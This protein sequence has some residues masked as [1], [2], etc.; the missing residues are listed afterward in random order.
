VGRSPAFLFFLRIAFVMRL[1]EK[2]FTLLEPSVVDAGFALVAVLLSGEQKYRALE[3]LIER[4]NG[5]AVTLDD[6]EIVS[7]Q[8]SA[9]LEV[10]DYI[11]GRYRLE[12]SSPGINRPLVRPADF[13]RFIGE[14]V[15]VTMNIHFD[16]RKRFSGILSAADE[17]EFSLQLSDTNAIVKLPYAQVFSARLDPSEESLRMALREGKKQMKQEKIQKKKTK[18]KS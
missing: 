10:E 2:I 17:D 8:L 3:I 7:K 11:Q 13:Q 12:V 15:K 18:K 9:I 6:C 16:E 4:Q 5:S 1:E 14:S